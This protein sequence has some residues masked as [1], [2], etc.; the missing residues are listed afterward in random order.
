MRHFLG[1]LI[2]CS[3]ATPAFANS[4]TIVITANVP[5]ECQLTTTANFAEVGQGL[6]RI[7]S[8]NQFCNTGY[9]L[10]VQNAGL[11]NPATVQ[12]RGNSANVS[13]GMT[14]L[15]SAGKPVNGASDLFL[16]TQNR[17]DAENFAQTVYLSVTPTG[18]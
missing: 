10:T 2:A 4:E 5:T 6:Y 17:A 8:V 7:A 15:I 12:F 16:S 9:A 3:I 1:L 14:Q 18:V 11:A 13:S